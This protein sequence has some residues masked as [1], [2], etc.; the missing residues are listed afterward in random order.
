MPLTTGVVAEFRLFVLLVSKPFVSIHASFTTCS[1]LGIL[2]SLM[3]T[4][5]SIGVSFIAI[6]SISQRIKSVT[7][8]LLGAVSR[9]AVHTPL[10]ELTAP[11]KLK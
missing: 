4:R 1:P 6:R 9:L 2:L 3:G 7:W 5:I 10:E 8:L 11:F